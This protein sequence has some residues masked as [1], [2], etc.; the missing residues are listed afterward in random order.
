MSEQQDFAHSLLHTKSVVSETLGELRHAAIITQA[1]IKTGIR[2]SIRMLAA[3]VLFSISSIF[4]IGATVGE[5]LASTLTASHSGQHSAPKQHKRGLRHHLKLTKADKLAARQAAEVSETSRMRPILGVASWYGG[6]FQHRKTASGSTFETQDFTAAHRSLPF[7][8]KVRVTNLLNHKSCIVEITD[9][10]PYVESRAIDVSRAAAEVLD[11]A[12]LGTAH[13]S[14]EVL[15][16]D[17]SFGGD[18]LLASLYG[19]LALGVKSAH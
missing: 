8:T 15:P 11:F 9:R 12:S 3:A 4:S 1:E 5:A 13:V 18:E 7:G 14:L 19:P 2:A 16:N 10:G 6:K 17:A